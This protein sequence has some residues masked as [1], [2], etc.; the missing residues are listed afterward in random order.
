MLLRSKVEWWNASGF[1]VLGRELNRRR[2]S[3]ASSAA[4]FVGKLV[5]GVRY[6]VLESIRPTR[7]LGRTRVVVVGLMLFFSLPHV[8]SANKWMNIGKTSDSSWKFNDFFVFW[9]IFRR[10]TVR[11]IVWEIFFDDS[12]LRRW[13]TNDDDGSRVVIKR[14]VRYRS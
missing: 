4:S 9:F 10:I 7:I 13:V 1:V 11:E 6:M 8:T 12:T 14:S 5:F 3:F 2:Y